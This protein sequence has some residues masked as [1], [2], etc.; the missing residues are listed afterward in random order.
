MPYIWEWIIKYIIEDKKNI[1]IL[2]IVA[3]FS[4]MSGL[5]SGLMSE[6]CAIIALVICLGSIPRIVKQ[7]IRHWN[8]VEEEEP[9]WGEEN[10]K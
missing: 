1:T 7:T 8:D 10:E 6:A 9:A 3:V 5:M 2:A 4:A